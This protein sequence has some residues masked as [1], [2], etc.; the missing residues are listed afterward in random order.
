MCY[1]MEI[2]L[3][4]G[5]SGLILLLAGLSLLIFKIIKED[6]KIYLLLNIFGGGFL[7]IYSYNLKSLP[8]MILEAIWTIIPLYK[9]IFSKK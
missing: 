2:S 4:V 1:I 7:F 5:V 9:I 3:I 6:S 8:F